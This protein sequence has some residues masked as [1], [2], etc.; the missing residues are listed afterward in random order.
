MHNYFIG[1][2]DLSLF[3]ILDYLQYYVRIFLH[4][5]FSVLEY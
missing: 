5:F 1:K 2:G 3:L 4:L